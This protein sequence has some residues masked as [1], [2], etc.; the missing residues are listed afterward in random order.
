MEC[1]L[2]INRFLAGLSLGCCVIS[3]VSYGSII[4][5]NNTLS[6]NGSDA[7]VFAYDQ[8]TVNLG[9]GSDV[10]FMYMHDQ[11][12]VSVTGGSL[13]WLHLY[14]Q[15]TAAIHQTDISW[16]LMADNSIATV[17]GSDFSY[18]GGILSGKWSD[19]TAFSFWALNFNSTNYSP[20]FNT[21]SMPRNLSLHNVPTP[22]T[23]PLLVAALIPVLAFSRKLNK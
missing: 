13:S 23:L 16:L 17:Y 19:G 4:T 15:S 12:H 2:Q 20:I 18:S 22:G 9:I 5:G 6:I 1:I 3:N 10:A 8:A 14:E 11:S 21:S 7:F